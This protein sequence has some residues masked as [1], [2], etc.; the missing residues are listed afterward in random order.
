MKIDMNFITRRRMLAVDY[1]MAWKIFFSRTL[2]EEMA[3]VLITEDELIVAEDIKSSLIKYGHEVLAIVTT[4]ADT[5]DKIEELC[6]DVIL[7]DIML[8]GEM[9]GV[10]TAQYINEHFDI[11]VV[12]LT[13]YSDEGTMRR[14]FKTAPFGFLLKPFEE[15]QLYATIEMAHYMHCEILS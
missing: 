14:A 11:P 3:R 10:E 1:L 15:R 8:S 2:E 4:G 13:A 12:Y 5:I 9:D 7:M 6:P